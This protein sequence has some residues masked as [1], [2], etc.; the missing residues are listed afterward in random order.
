MSRRRTG[1]DLGI[2][3]EVLLVLG[4]GTGM[5]N[6]PDEWLRE[7]WCRW[8]G[9]LVAYWRDHFDGEPFAAAIARLEGWPE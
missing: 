8:R 1:R 3:A 4:L 7:Q 9:P 5:N 2:P 6:C